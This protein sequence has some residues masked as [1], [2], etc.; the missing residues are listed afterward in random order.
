MSQYNY[1]KKEISKI[2]KKASEIQTHKE[3][4]GDKDV[5][6]K[7]ELFQLATEVGIDKESLEE[8]LHH[9]D[10]PELEN[11]FQW[12][13]G[14]SNIQSVEIFKGEMTDKLWDEMIQTMRTEVGGIGEVSKQ[15]NI[16]EW[17]QR[18]DDIGFR[19]ITFTPQKGSTKVQYSYRWTGL[20][21][22]T[23]F[24]I[25]MFAF[26][27]S[28]VSLSNTTIPEA[29]FVPISLVL[30]GLGSLA[31]RFY[32]K[33]YFERKKKTMFR[34][35]SK[36]SETFNRQTQAQQEITLEDPE[37]YSSESNSENSS[38]HPKKEHL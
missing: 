17:T 37:V 4:Y 14:T 36:L 35:M 11:T 1:S 19:Q 18:F 25:F 10:I 12:L 28:M 38:S 15:G 31:N 8:A 16:Y 9:K 21:F 23:G 27:I 24:F 33:S 20:K 26:G 29:M 3:L 22:A 30:G 7:E 2:L 5:L 32:L 34:V 6:T 13:K